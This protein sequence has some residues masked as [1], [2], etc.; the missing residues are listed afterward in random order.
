MKK[1]F[2]LLLSC[3]YVYT[4]SLAQS[5][6]G[7]IWPGKIWLDSS[8][9]PINA[10]GGGMLYHNG[11]YYWFG[12]VKKGQTWRVPGISSWED[13][14]VNAGGV[15]CYTS[16][17]LVHWA[18]KSLALSPEKN[19]SASEIHISKVIERPKVIF[20]AKTKKF[21]MWMHIDKE[22]YSYAHAGVA[23]SDKPEGPYH[24]LRSYR[25]NGQESRD[26]T[27]FQ[28]EDQKAYIVYA[29]E[30]NMTMQICLL[31]EDY[32]KPTTTYRRILINAHREAPA[33][34][35][36]NRQYY[37]ITSLCTGWDPNMALFASADDPLAKWTMWDNPCYGP[38]ADSTYHAQSTYVF[39]IAGK[40]NEFV[41]MADRWNKTDLEHSTYVWLPLYVDNHKP[42]INWS[43]QWTPILK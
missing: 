22:D 41:F 2:I 12:E 8:N 40:R 14:R 26:M 15:A 18:Y 34:F 13:Y 3:F 24:Y 20:N 35:K 28:D 23:Q 4:S 21:V 31:S 7:K 17:D 37:L 33:L 38:D 19:D 5:N 10:H 29:S 25:P 36:F 6:G 27:I 9:Q 16:E 32:L 11:V 1:I 30:N 39:P 43:A 42:Y